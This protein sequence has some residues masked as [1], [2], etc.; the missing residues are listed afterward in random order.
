MDW[1]LKTC[2]LATLYAAPVT[3]QPQPPKPPAPDPA[4]EAGPVPGLAPLGPAFDRFELDR[5][6]DEARR[7]AAE[8]KATFNMNVMNQVTEQMDAVREKARTLGLIA[9]NF[10]KDFKYEWK[11]GNSEDGRYREGTRLLDERKWERAVDVFSGIVSRGG[12][13]SDGALYWKAYA[14]HKLGRRP[15]AQAALA[16]LA[17]SY[18]AS[19][20]LNDS[21]ALS[22]EISQASG[23]PVSPES[24]DDDELK[25]IALN[26]LVNSDPERA[27]PLIEKLLM[28]SHSPKM[29]ERALFV[30]AQSGSVKGR[31]T[32]TQI[33]RGKSNPDLQLKALRYLGT[34][35]KGKESRQVLGEIYSSATSVEVKREILRGFVANGD[36]ERVVNAAKTEA[37]P[38]LRRDAI[39]LMGEMRA[40]VELWQMYQGAAPDIKQEILRAMAGGGNSDKLLEILKTD[41]D[42]K[43]R[44]EALRALQRRD[45]AKNGESIAALYPGEADAEVKKEILR[46]MARQNN[47]KILVE[48]ARKE[49]NPAL[50][51]E[52]VQNL[53]RMKSKEAAD[54]LLEVLNK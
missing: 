21:K 16:D 9:Q 19:G 10:D 5:I 40:D 6:A 15:E 4:P 54:F 45:A 11:G 42:S 28:G 49:T 27:V 24:Q 2:L 20:W 36:R 32:L 39:R 25:L 17:K 37:S 48:L 22:V 53:S 1:I 46:T 41:K 44:L 18:P 29:K 52:A 12:S 14:L 34:A 7:I 50:K 26:G 38:E 8:V 30:L 51:R 13:R 43:L 3:A 23:Q 33:A 31:E 47:V 35:M